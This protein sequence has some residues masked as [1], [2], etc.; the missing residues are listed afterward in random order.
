MKPRTK[1]ILLLLFIFSVALILRF[2]K[3]GVIPDGLQQDESSIGYN[4]YSILLTGKDEHGVFLPQNFQ[5]F[6]EYKLP[7]YIYASVVPIA[8]FGLNPFAIRFVSAV[9]GFLSVVVVF[10]LTKTLIH[11]FRRDP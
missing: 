9:S 11:F 7:G 2:Y 3:L 8:V 10:F 5:A 4:A 1:K 6:G